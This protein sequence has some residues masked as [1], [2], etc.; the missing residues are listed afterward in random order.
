MTKG[1][2]CGTILIASTDITRWL[3]V[4][5]RFGTGHQKKPN[6]N[7]R[8]RLLLIIRRI[9]TA[10]EARMGS[11]S[12]LGDLQARLQGGERANFR[13]AKFPCHKCSTYSGNGSP[14][15]PDSHLRLSGFFDYPFRYENPA[16]RK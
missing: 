2:F 13:E 5:Y 3:S 7:F 9:D 10:C 16:S 15:N 12:P 1:L 14:K 6:P 4:Q 8:V 11:V